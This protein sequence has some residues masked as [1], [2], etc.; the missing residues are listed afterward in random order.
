MKMDEYDDAYLD[1][2]SRFS[3][4]WLID[5]PREKRSS[6]TQIVDGL[7]EMAI[8]VPDLGH[9]SARR[10]PGYSERARDWLGTTTPRSEPVDI[11]YFGSHTT[12]AASG[13]GV[14]ERELNPHG[15][16]LGTHPTGR[17]AV[18]KIAGQGLAGVSEDDLAR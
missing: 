12:A 10:W 1:R 8:Q 11:A 13:R 18:R 14:S 6:V 5:R 15:F 17:R 2:G 4:H 9:T 7:R 3:L 16:D